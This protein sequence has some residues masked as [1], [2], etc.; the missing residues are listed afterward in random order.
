M[1]LGTNAE[2]E[3]LKISLTAGIAFGVVYDILAVL[4]RLLPGRA[5]TFVCDMFYALLFAAGYFTVS[6]ALTN[7]LRGFVLTA[8]LAGAAAWHF[9][10][11]RGAVWLISRTVSLAVRKILLPPVVSVY[12]FGRQICVKTVGNAIN[13][14]KSKK[15]TQ[16]T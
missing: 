2:I 4:R 15:I 8:M 14:L 13:S 1:Q 16:S 12:K 6:L 7:Y 10:A 3:V 11:G 5:V 9:T